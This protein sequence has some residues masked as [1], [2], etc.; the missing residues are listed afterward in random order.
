MGHPP[1]PYRIA[2]GEDDVVLA[3][4]LAEGGRAEPPVERLVGRVVGGS[5][6]EPTPAGSPNGPPGSPIST[7]RQERP[8]LG[9]SSARWQTPG[10]GRR[11]TVERPGA[12]CDGQV[13]CGTRP[14]PLR[15]AAFRP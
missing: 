14:D 13:G 10:A 12:R 3:P 2:Q 5:P 1:V 8:A 15:A 9:Q 7:G 11:G 4:D 6:S